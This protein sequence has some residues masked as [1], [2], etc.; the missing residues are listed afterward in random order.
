MKPYRKFDAWLNFVFG[1]I[2]FVAW[3]L[4]LYRREWWHAGVGF[5]VLLFIGWAEE[6]STKKEKAGNV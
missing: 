1:N 3:A 2:A 5:G 6:N 4:G